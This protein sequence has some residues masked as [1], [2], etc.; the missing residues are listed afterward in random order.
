MEFTIG[1]DIPL[2]PEDKAGGVVLNYS[3]YPHVVVNGTV[4]EGAL[5]SLRFRDLTS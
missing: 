1:R 4:F 3:I 5:T 2:I